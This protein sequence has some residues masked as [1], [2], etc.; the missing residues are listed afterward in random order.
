MKKTLSMLLLSAC[1]ALNASAQLANGYY[2]IQNTYT[3]RYISIEDNNTEHYP[4]SSSGQVTMYGIRT[5][6]PGKKVSTSPST[7]VYV[8]NI[9]GTEYDIEGQG[10]SIHYISGNR[11]YINLVAQPDGSYQAYGHHIITIYLA[12]DTDTDVEESYIKNRS[13]KTRNWWARAV[14][15]DNEFLG[16]DPDV[17]ID[18]K[19]YGSFYASFPIRLV[20]SGMKAYC[21]TEAAGSGFTMQEINGDIPAMT[22]VVIEC[23]S[24]NYANNKV[25]PVSSEPSLGINNLLYGTLCARVSTK[26]TQAE[27]Y[28]PATMRTLGKSNGKLAFV[29]ANANDLVSGTYMKAHKAY[30]LVPSNASDVLVWGGSTS[31]SNPT[32]EKFS[33]SGATYTTA[34][35]YTVTLNKVDDKLDGPF[36]MPEMV[37]YNGQNYTITAIGNNAFENQSSMTGVSIPSTV[38]SIGEKAFAGCSGLV[39]IYTFATEP[40]TLAASAFEGVSMENCIVYVPA[41][42]VEKYKAAEGWKNFPNIGLAGEGIRDITDTTVTNDR[43]YS[44]DGREIKAQPTKKG[45]Y[46]KNGKK[47]V[48]K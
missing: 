47:V 3:D 40:P 18:G 23:S 4:V 1:C 31:P 38:T 32:G 28:N 25:L 21:V 29:K 2:R 48:I 16:I 45:I 14:N 43:W 34:A 24:N 6:K 12:D 5:V 36:Q 27:F 20:S 44:L 15:T 17:E 7:I 30:L 11:M 13:E 19:Y 37:Q 46:I 10:T 22:P 8:R 42:C 41:G 39:A 33:T 9:Q 26:Y 35:N